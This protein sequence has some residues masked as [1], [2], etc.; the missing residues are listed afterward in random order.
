MERTPRIPAADHSAGFV[1][2]SAKPGNSLRSGG[3]LAGSAVCDDRASRS[4]PLSGSP[5]TTHAAGHR[6]KSHVRR[7]FGCSGYRARS[8]TL[9]LRHR[10]RK[11][12]GLTMAQPSEVMPPKGLTT[13][14]TH[15]LAYRKATDRV[16]SETMSEGLSA[17]DISSSP[18]RQTVS[19]GRT[20]RQTATTACSHGRQERTTRQ[21]TIRCETTLVA[22]LVIFSTRLGFLGSYRP[23]HI[24]GLHQ[25]FSIASARDLRRIFSG[26]AMRPKTAERSKRLR[27]S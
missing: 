8:R 5:R 22:R 7:S 10:L 12:Q 20:C 3:F 11:V 13:L 25:R 16:F 14:I 15:L 24:R 19:H 17:G 6:R 26:G 4:A 18:D 23:P 27:R 1:S 2:A 21:R 9:L